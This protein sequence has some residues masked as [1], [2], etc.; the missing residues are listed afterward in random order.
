MKRTILMGILV[1]ATGATGLMAKD[2]KDKNAKNDKT[3]PQEAAQPA[4]PKG[5]APKSQG[6]AEALQ[7]LAKA[8]GNPDATIA[9][10]DNLVTKYADTAFKDVALFME[11]QAYRQK[12][13][14][15][16]AQI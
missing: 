10:A 7:A 13:D 8:Q 12:G 6:E 14:P 9:A 5:P 4:Q 2:K 16:K 15:V 3:A 1:L 11:A